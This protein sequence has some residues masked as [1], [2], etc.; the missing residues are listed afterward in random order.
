MNELIKFK[1][2]FV[3][4]LEAGF[5]A[6]NQADEDS[7]TKLFKAAALLNKTS[8][9]PQ[10]G[11]GYLYLHKLELKQACK[12][13]EE[14]LKKEPHNDMA[15]ALLG[16]SMTMT[17]DQVAQ[18][19]KILSETAKSSSDSQVKTLAESALN[20]VEQFVKK[21]PSGKMPHTPPSPK[22]HHPSK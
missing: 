10:I 8:T 22:G 9:L 21:S 7:A 3:L 2:H 20:F 16:L 13:F 12:I 15:K 6:V 5:I 17:A 18:G 11:F 19:E 1:E 4:L 14:I